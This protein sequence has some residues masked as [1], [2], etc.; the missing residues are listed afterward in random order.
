MEGL[1]DWEHLDSLE[2]RLADLELDFPPTPDIMAAV[3]SRLEGRQTRRL[4]V[5]LV[6]ALALALMAA[7][8]GALSP[9]ARSLVAT[10]LQL[11][12]VK[13]ERMPELKTGFDRLQPLPLG[14]RVTLEEARRQ[15]NF[16]LLV[17]AGYD[18]LYLDYRPSGSALTFVWGPPSEPQKL[19][20]EFVGRTEPAFLYKQAG[21]DTHVE[22]LRLNG[23]PA[24]WVSGAPHVV[25]YRY[26]EVI[27]QEELHLAGDVLIWQR[28]E[29]VLRLEGAERG[30]ALKLAAELG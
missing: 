16:T 3:S 13:I 30:P 20:T 11:D 1:E 6:P 25:Y 2:R 4:R 21:P 8:A 9:D 15:S 19:L 29:V 5:A 22:E 10:L 17:P 14:R 23:S 24:F 12:G 7:T 18:S 27:D 26:G 28:G